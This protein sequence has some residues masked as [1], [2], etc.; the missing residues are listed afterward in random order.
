L[1]EAVP[2][3][4][5]V[6]NFQVKWEADAWKL[7]L[8]GTLQATGSPPAPTALADAVGTLADRLVNGPFH[9]T[10][11]KRSDRAEVGRD[12]TVLLGSAPAGD[13]PVMT[14]QFLIEGVMR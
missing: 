3:E 9:V 7:H 5:V 10:I 6:T 11:Q 4:L 13:A 1:S 8:A 14:N 2:P 12:L